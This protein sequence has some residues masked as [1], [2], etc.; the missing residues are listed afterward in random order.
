MVRGDSSHE[1]NKAVYFFPKVLKWKK[2]LSYC[3]QWGSIQEIARK[4]TTIE[5]R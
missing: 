5:S 4:R 1:T 2:N 3:A